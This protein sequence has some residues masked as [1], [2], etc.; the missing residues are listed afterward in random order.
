MAPAWSD[1]VWLAA[2]FAAGFG[3]CRWSLSPAAVGTP[4]RHQ[5]ATAVLPTRGT[6]RPSACP[7]PPHPLPAPPAPCSCAPGAVALGPRSEEQRLARYLRALPQRA[8]SCAGWLPVNH[9]LP[10]PAALAHCAARWLAA[11]PAHLLN[12]T[13]PRSVFDFGFDGLPHP[14]AAAV[15]DS[16]VFFTAWLP[17]SGPPPPPRLPLPQKQVLLAPPTAIRLAALVVSNSL[18]D[19]SLLLRLEELQYTIQAVDLP[20]LLGSLLGMARTAFVLLPCSAQGDVLPDSFIRN[21]TRRAV[22]VTTDLGVHVLDVR[23]AEV[24]VLRHLTC[25]RALLQ[26]TVQKVHRAVRLKWC[27]YPAGTKYDLVYRVD[28]WPQLVHRYLMQWTR[29]GGDKVKTIRKWRPSM[30]LADVLG[31][32]VTAAHREAI[33]WDMLRHPSCP[34]PAVQNWL[35]TEGGE[36]ERIDANQQAIK[37]KHPEGSSYVEFLRLQ[38][39]L[40][41]RG[42]WKQV[43]RKE[44]LLHE[45]ADGEHRFVVSKFF[46]K[47]NRTPGKW[48]DFAPVDEDPYAACPPCGAC[49]RHAFPVFKMWRH[50]NE[51]RPPAACHACYACQRARLL[52]AGYPTTGF[53][54]CTDVE[55]VGAEGPDRPEFCDAAVGQPLPRPSLR[56]LCRQLRDKDRRCS[57]PPDP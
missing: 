28:E 8:V 56:L 7:S 20:L 45:S 18:F 16:W 21:A 23:V 50:G 15:P 13:Q 48:D 22:E 5:V 9:S 32:G 43:D 38:T 52:G 31:W 3:V 30:N 42:P 49:V 41:R 2:A 57:A 40:S 54:V 36:V 27:F 44:G 29:A 47:N 51:T 11:H 4:P 12:T 24:V 53:E 26:V 25:T 34:D 55:G 37:G 46:R 6:A 10:P 17:P 39:C 1:A 14:L 19:V 33:L 35:M